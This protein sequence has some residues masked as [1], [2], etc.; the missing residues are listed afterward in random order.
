MSRANMR[1]RG[2]VHWRKKFFKH[3]HWFLWKVLREH[4]GLYME[5]ENYVA[6][7]GDQPEPLSSGKV[8]S[9]TFPVVATLLPQPVRGFVYATPTAATGL[10]G[11]W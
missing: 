5:L 4:N 11:L 10:M 8:L 9:A 7:R 1:R 6:S 3:T 2:E